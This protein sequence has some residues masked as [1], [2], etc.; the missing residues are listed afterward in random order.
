MRRPFVEVRKHH[1][2][3]SEA[4]ARFEKS[5]DPQ[6]NIMALERFMYVLRQ[7]G[8]VRTDAHTI[9][10][11][12]VVRQPPK[13]EVAH[14]FIEHKLGV[15]LAPAFVAIHSKIGIFSTRKRKWN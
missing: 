2:I 1:K 4:S 7:E 5:L 6:Q 9:V 8:I 15:S 10:S 11:L 13:I 14:R 3:R 12:G